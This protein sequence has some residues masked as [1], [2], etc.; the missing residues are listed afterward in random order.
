MNEFHAYLNNDG[1]YRLE[2]LTHVFDNSGALLKSKFI[3]SRAKITI[4]PLVDTD[5]KEIY[6]LI[7]ED[8]EN[9]TT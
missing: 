6:S 2:V 9:E 8:E 4:E 7:V 5:T 3:V 1:T